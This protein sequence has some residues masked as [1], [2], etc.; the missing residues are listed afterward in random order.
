MRMILISDNTDT[1]MGLRLAGIEGVVVHE[2]A[3]VIK[4]LDQYTQ[5]NDVAIILMTTNIVNLCPD[6]ISDLKLK[7]SKPLLVEIPDRHGSV[8]IGEVIDSYISE[9]IGVKLGG[10]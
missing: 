6:I 3:E 7:L 2:K 1:G 4:A 8:K 10:D 9:A 5:Q